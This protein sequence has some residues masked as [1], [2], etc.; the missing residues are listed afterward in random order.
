MTRTVDK[1]ERLVLAFIEN[2]SIT[3]AIE[4]K[5]IAGS[6]FLL[7]IQVS[8]LKIANYLA[9]VLDGL[10][11]KTEVTVFVVQSDEALG[12]KVG[13]LVEIRQFI[14]V[15]GYCDT[16]KHSID[17]DQRGGLVTGQ[18]EGMEDV[19]DSQQLA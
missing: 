9:V 6:Q 5:F 16:E 4:L 14:Q 3:I 1:E 7:T 19:Q 12:T 18:L 8:R 15:F 2:P 11:D 13:E 17:K 10:S